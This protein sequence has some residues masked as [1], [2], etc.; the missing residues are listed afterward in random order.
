MEKNPDLTIIGTGDGK[1]LKPVNELTNTQK[2]EVYMN[3]CI[4]QIFKYGIYLK[5]CKRLKTKEDKEKLSNIYDDIF[6]NNVK[7]KELIERYFKYT[8][9]ISQNKNN[10]AYLNDTCREV[11]KEIRKAENR[12]AEYEVGEVM[13]C[14]EYLKTTLDFPGSSWSDS[15]GEKKDGALSNEIAPTLG[16]ISR[17]RVGAAPKL[18]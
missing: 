4:N 14:T 1:Q 18:P 3:S 6:E 7:P 9:V 8:K 17:G 13:I 2:H 15:A 11:S 10:I 12:N 16:R 5:E